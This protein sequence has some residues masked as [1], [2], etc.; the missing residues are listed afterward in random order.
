MTRL[1]LE[2]PDDLNRF[3]KRA[4]ESG[5][6]PTTDEFFVSVLTSLKEQSEADFSPEELSKLSA[7]RAEIGL[8]EEQLASGESVTDPDW[9]AF[10]AERHRVFAGQPDLR[11]R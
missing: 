7:L 6:F 2:L 8:A 5:D 1:A 4:M 10:L 3:V 9:D 11:Q